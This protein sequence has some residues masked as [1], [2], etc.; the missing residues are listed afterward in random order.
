MKPNQRSGKPIDTAVFVS[1]AGLVAAAMGLCVAISLPLTAVICGGLILLMITLYL[2]APRTAVVLVL[3]GPLLLSTIKIGGLTLD[4]AVTMAGFALLVAAILLQNRKIRGVLTEPV[5]MYLVVLAFIV[6]FSALANPGGAKL[7]SVLRYVTLALLVYHLASHGPKLVAFAMDTLE[8][9]LV[10]GA[11][12]IF[13]QPIV[14]WPAPFLSKEGVIGAARFGGLFGH[15]NFAAYPLL[16]GVLVL[17][18]S[19]RHALWARFTE[20]VVLISAA[21]MTGSRTAVVMFVILL[22]CVAFRRGE[23]FARSLIVVIVAALP[24]ASVATSR[25]LSIIS[26]GGVAGDNAGGWRLAQWQFALDLWRDNV[27]FGVGWGNAQNLLPSNLG[28]HSAYLEVLAETGI[29]GFILFV[30]ALVSLVR[31]YRL[32]PAVLV[33]VGYTLLTGVSDRT[34]LYPSVLCVLC[35]GILFIRGG[36]GNPI[37][38]GG[39]DSPPSMAVQTFGSATRPALTGFVAPGWSLRNG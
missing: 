19:K 10:V 5:G 25:F 3:S 6:A 8:T 32:Y 35:V 33:L 12:S 11:C 15:P 37:G 16:L 21:M 39:K 1:S 17:V 20:S 4:N 14:G 36:V 24:F 27:L 26:T 7:S 13:L 9:L 18:M 2:G 34:L 23:S 29:V 30:F 38:L 28:V 31:G 22:L